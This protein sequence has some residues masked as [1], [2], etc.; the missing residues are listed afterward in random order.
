MKSGADEK[1]IQKQLQ[2]RDLDVAAKK[3]KRKKKARLMLNKKRI[4]K[5]VLKPLKKKTWKLSSNA[6]L[7]EESGSTSEANDTTKT[8]ARTGKKKRNNSLMDILTINKEG[9][10]NVRIY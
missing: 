6:E 5:K 4:K 2:K 1:E 9:K 8:D 10:S 3:R 7:N